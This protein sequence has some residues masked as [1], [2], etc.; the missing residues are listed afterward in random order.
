MIFAY[1]AEADEAVYSE[2]FHHGGDNEIGKGES[3]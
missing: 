3:I 1:G 2:I